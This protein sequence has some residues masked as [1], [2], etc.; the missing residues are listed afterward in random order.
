MIFKDKIVNN[1]LNLLIVE[2]R[3]HYKAF[4]CIHEFYQ[5]N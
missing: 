2:G 4:K 5:E 1:P 3:S